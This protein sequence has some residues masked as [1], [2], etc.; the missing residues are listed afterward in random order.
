MHTYH[1]SGNFHVEIIRVL[2]I[3]VNLFSW[4]YDTHENILTQAYFNKNI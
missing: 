4:V 3:H 2:N 1:K